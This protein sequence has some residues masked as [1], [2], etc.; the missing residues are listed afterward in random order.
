MAYIQRYKKHSAV[1]QQLLAERPLQDLYLD[2]K[3]EL[4]SD[5]IVI[6]SE[7][8]D[9]Q[10]SLLLDDL[11]YEW[12]NDQ[13]PPSYELGMHS[14]VKKDDGYL[15]CLL[16]HLC[17]H[18]VVCIVDTQHAVFHCEELYHPYGGCSHCKIY[19][20]YIVLEG[21]MECGLSDTRKHN[22]L[23]ASRE[24]LWKH[25]ES[26][27]S[28]EYYHHGKLESHD[29]IVNS[30]PSRQPRYYLARCDELH[31]IETLPDHTSNF[32]ITSDEWNKITIKHNKGGRVVINAVHL[33]LPN[34]VRYLSFLQFQAV[35][36]SE[37]YVMCFI[38]RAKATRLAPS[39][40]VINTLFIVDL[41][42]ERWY[43]RHLDNVNICSK[44]AICEHSIHLTILDDFEDPTYYIVKSSNDGDNSTPALIP[45]ADMCT[46]S[47]RYVASSF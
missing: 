43:A 18:C 4:F 17:D 39:G 32:T 31:E 46:Y 20:E 7:K 28:L 38:A 19:P 37:G 22:Y 44:I 14:V 36:A 21:E 26:N 9:V 29:L 25:R 45:R 10:Y 8:Y 41:E 33:D 47:L 40:V 12:N 24:F 16:I 30:P 11:P 6:T 35:K 5:R 1:I 27:I 42:R 3:Y 15:M 23:L 34:N 13:H 2:F